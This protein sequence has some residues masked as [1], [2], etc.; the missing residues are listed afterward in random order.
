LQA[1]T[2]LGAI[3]VASLFFLYDTYW[4]GAVLSLSS[5]PYSGTPVWWTLVAI[6]GM[7]ADPLCVGFAIA[8]ALGANRP[9]QGGVP[10]T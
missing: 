6:T 10:A 9:R 5:F 3:G 2:V 1:L 7:I 8:T 4:F